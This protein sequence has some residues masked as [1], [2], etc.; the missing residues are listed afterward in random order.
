MLFALYI[1][2]MGQELAQSSLGVLLHRVNVSAILFA[3]SRS[4]VPPGA[5]LVVHYNILFL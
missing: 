5:V 2:E 3:V 4:R 1:A